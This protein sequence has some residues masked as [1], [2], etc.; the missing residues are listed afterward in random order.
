L[1][2]NFP[3]KSTLVAE[4][5][6]AVT[7]IHDQ[8]KSFSRAVGYWAVMGLNF[9]TDLGAPE[10]RYVLASYFIAD[11]R[12]EEQLLA[13][14][15]PLECRQNFCFVHSGLVVLAVPRQDLNDGNNVSLLEKICD[16][17]V[18]GSEI[19]IDSPDKYARL[20]FVST[21]E[22]NPCCRVSTVPS[23]PIHGRTGNASA[24]EAVS[25]VNENRSRGVD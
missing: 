24:S 1:S 5:H 13:D 20:H 16:R 21:E 2:G 11:K 15:C 8:M 17:R 3:I 9:G 12:S 18:P 14:V 6:D 7:L 4:R 22:F 23:P 19:S 10:K 25:Q